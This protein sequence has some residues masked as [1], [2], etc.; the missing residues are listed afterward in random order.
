[1]K[2]IRI[3]NDGSVDVINTPPAPTGIKY[4]IVR[5]LPN[6][7]QTFPFE[8]MSAPVNDQDIPVRIGMKGNKMPCRAWFDFLSMIQTPQAYRWAIEPHVWWINDRYK[9]DSAWPDYDPQGNAPSDAEPISEC[10]WY[11]LNYIAYDYRVGDWFHLVS[12]SNTSPPTDPYTDNWVT[13]PWLFCKAQMRNKDGT[14]IYNVG[15]GL[16]AYL[17]LIKQTEHTWMHLTHIEPFPSLPYT[18][19]DG[20]II[21]SYQLQ[22]A[23]VIGTTQS[24]ACLFLRKVG[25]FTGISEPFG[26]H[27]QTPSVIPPEGF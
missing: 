25:K 27:L 19:D 2:N 5:I 17:P 11:P 6:P 23:N 3:Y 14:I 16:D 8:V 7:G 10:I 26:W 1:M 21:V 4:A 20:T 9:G 22:G 24:G 13:K 12:Y 18:L 15:S